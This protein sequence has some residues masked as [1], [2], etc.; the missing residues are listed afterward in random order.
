MFDTISYFSIQLIYLLYICYD[1]IIIY[2]PFTSRIAN[3][4]KYIIC[5]N[6]IGCDPNLLESLIN[7]LPEW[8]NYEKQGLTINYI[9]KEIPTEFIEYMKII[10]NYIVQIQ[11]NN[12]NN[13]IN[14]INNKNDIYNKQW[15]K[16]N[17]KKQ[18][19]NAIEWAKKYK[20]SY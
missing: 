9:F 1:N 3:S 14:I 15:K 7:I 8:N 16:E 4:E 11:I 6:Y 5:R 19:Q 17:N 20:I 18:I 13:T 2:K 12:I 10:N